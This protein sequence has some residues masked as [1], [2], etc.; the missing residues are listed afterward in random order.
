MFYS[1]SHSA[2]IAFGWFRLTL[3]KVDVSYVGV[4]QSESGENHF[5]PCTFVMRWGPILKVLF[6]LSQLS[7]FSSQG[8][9]LRCHPLVM[10]SLSGLLISVWGIALWG[11]VGALN[12][13]SFAAASAF[14]FPRTLTCPWTQHRSMIISSS[15][16][17]RISSLVSITI[18][19]KEESDLRAR[20]AL[21]ESEKTVNRLP[22]MVQKQL[23]EQAEDFTLSQHKEEWKLIRLL[24][25]RSNHHP[26][27][28]N[29]TKPML[30]SS[31]KQ[32]SSINGIL[33]FMNR[34]MT[35]FT[36][37]QIP[38]C[39]NHTKNKDDYIYWL[40]YW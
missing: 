6:D 40:G 29:K 16:A 23:Q 7:S 21:L 39:Q 15:L 32:M 34:W 30:F 18:G 22:S 3:H 13:A 19:E 35:S 36:V 14:S 2:S 8:V 5:Y 20:R 25:K 24:L 31:K 9:P 1:N 12:A 38:L 28:S 11:A 10:A 17:L 33:H 27:S 37:Q 4:T 26:Q